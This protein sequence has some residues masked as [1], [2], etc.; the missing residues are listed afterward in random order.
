MKK[1]EF[2]EYLPNFVKDTKDLTLGSKNVLAAL[3]FL[4]NNEY[5][6]ENG[7]FYRSNRDLCKDAEV[8]E[9]T[10]IKS[11]SQ[12]EVMGFI[13]RKVGKR[14]SGAS[15]YKINNDFLNGLKV[16]FNKFFGNAVNEE[17]IKVEGFTAKCSKECSNKSAVIENKKCSNQNTDKQRGF[18]ESAVISAVKKC[19]TDIDK[20]I[21]K[22]IIYNLNNNIIELN[23]N[24][25][26]IINIIKNNN[27]NKLINESV[28]KNNFT[29]EIEKIE[30]EALQAVEV[31]DTEEI[32]NL[33]SIEKENLE[34][35][36]EINESVAAGT[37][38][39]KE[40]ENNI[41]N[42]STEM[43]IKHESTVETTKFYPNAIVEQAVTKHSPS[44]HY[45]LITPKEQERI[46]T[47]LMERFMNSNSLEEV[48][49]KWRKFIKY[50]NSRTFMIHYIQQAQKAH[51]E[52]LKK[53]QPTEEPILSPLS[54]PNDNGGI[55]AHP[56]GEHPTDA[57]KDPLDGILFDSSTLEDDVTPTAKSEICSTSPS[58]DEDGTITPIEEEKPTEAKEMPLEVK[59]VPKRY[60]YLDLCKTMIDNSDTIEDLKECTKRINQLKNCLSTDEMAELAE[61]MDEKCRWVA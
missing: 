53:F 29:N 19:S 31:E 54:L 59:Y 7:F 6:K 22:D 47:E 42:T 37:L 15:E 9:H 41:I 28:L 16:D 51:Q 43:D 40:T 61:I 45:N 3:M 8:C 13:E 1:N 35:T 17:R 50:L 39:D 49:D 10:L 24:L 58:N 30:G 33:T 55:V 18:E 21:D 60:S 4:N 11:L 57:T 36:K 26:E 14:G 52:L 25:K 34:Y 12:L 2:F 46:F 20:E 27:K 38:S 5:S 23:K 48:E 32:I 44:E 56:K